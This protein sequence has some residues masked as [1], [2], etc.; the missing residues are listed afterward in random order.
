MDLKKSG[1]SLEN[2]ETGLFALLG[3]FV[4]TRLNVLV[5]RFPPHD[6]VDGVTKGAHPCQ[7][8]YWEWLSFLS[9]YGAAKSTRV[10][11]RTFGFGTR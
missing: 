1:P 6:Y 7:I 9:L 8:K 3:L 4:G 2:M 5:D 11:F 10:P